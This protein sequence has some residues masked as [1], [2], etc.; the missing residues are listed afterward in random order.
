MAVRPIRVAND[1]KKLMV[2]R[3]G[4][5]V[6]HFQ[7][8]GLLH[9]PSSRMEDDQKY[10]FIDLVIKTPFLVFIINVV[11]MLGI[12]L[13]VNEGDEGIQSQ[14]KDEKAD[15]MNTTN[16]DHGSS[17]SSVPVPEYQFVL[18]AEDFVADGPPPL[19]WIFNQL[20]GIGV[21][22]R[23]PLTSFSS[24]SPLNQLL[25]K[26]EEQKQQH[27]I[28]A[29]LRVWPSKAETYHYHTKNLDFDIP[30]D[31]IV[32]NAQCRAEINIKFPSILL[33]ILPVPKEVIERQGEKALLE[34]MERDILPGLLKFRRSYLRWLRK[35]HHT[36]D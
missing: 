25:L 22:K 9:S 2:N 13:A 12:K 15:N 7:R 29:F 23:K 31:N 4:Q 21:G 30:V 16:A 1:T 24:S 28:H 14:M 35:H 5:E 10:D 20:T 32:F 19:V 26:N 36:K 11:A 33:R 3:L 8:D 18:L 17:N 6:A 34:S 27:L